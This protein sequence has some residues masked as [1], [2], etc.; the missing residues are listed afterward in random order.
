MST[1]ACLQYLH[2]V[3]GVAQSDALSD[4]LLFPDMEKAIAR[5]EKAIRAKE[6][7]GIFGDYDADGVTGTAILV[8]ALRRRGVDPVVHLPDRMKEGYGMKEQSVRALAEKGVTLLLTVDTGIAA[9]EEI[10]L[11]SS[12]GIDTIV[13]DH[14]HVQGDAPSTFAIIHPA[15]SSFPNQ[16]LCGAGVAL[17]FVRALEQGG[18]WQG[19]DEDIVLTMIGTV[20]D[21]MPL[22]GE[23]RLLVIHGLK[24][25][26][27]LPDGP[28]KALID[29]VRAEGSITSGDIAFRVVP[30]LNAAGRMAH[31]SIALDALLEGGASLERL[32][33]LN[34]DRQSL[35]ASLMDEVL[36]TTDTTT[37][38]LTVLD[39][40]I[41][42]GIAG[43]IAG[44]L[45]ETTGKPSLVAAHMGEHATASLR[46]VPTVDCMT[47]LMD[48]EVRSLLLTYGGHAQAAGC[49]FLSSNFEMLSK[50]LC[51]VVSSLT[52]P[53]T[54]VPTRFVDAIL[55]DQPTLSFVHALSAL[56]PFG[57][58]N[59]EPLFLGQSQ[60]LGNLRAVGTDSAHLQCTIG[61][62]KAIGFRLGS[63]LPYLSPERTYDCLYRVSVNTWNG[64]DSV[65]FIL[66]DIRE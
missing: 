35:V 61:G 54:L 40:R 45:T 48:P 17:M 24:A 37:P 59:E 57:Q 51:R 12:L 19:I 13:T 30:R 39:P 14:H 56:A 6:V 66:E 25:I 60:L 20:G 58:G 23:N 65:Q 47:C 18:L 44:R 53:A 38:F 16:H 62:T 7:I 42:P 3:R 21:V 26:Q 52:D 64:R 31:P 41:T 43:L 32:H 63:L 1:I 8:R 34:G 50:E 11:A 55:T 4:P 9:H 33:A 10:A 2:G 29:S 46:S 5:V 36:K 27:Q 22:T 49:T 28:I 15:L